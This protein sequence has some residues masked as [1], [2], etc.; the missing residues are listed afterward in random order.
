MNM[1]MNMQEMRRGDVC[2]ICLSCNSLAAL[3]LIRM[4]S[5][6]RG[7]KKWYV[8][9]DH[10]Q[11][12]MIWG[13]IS[14]VA[15]GMKFTSCQ[16]VFFPRQLGFLEFCSRNFFPQK[17]HWREKFLRRKLVH[18]RGVAKPPKSDDWATC[19]S[20][21]FLFTNSDPQHKLLSTLRRARARRIQRCLWSL[22]LN[23]WPRNSLSKSKIIT[24]W[25]DLQ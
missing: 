3:C 7:H 2:T 8:E 23:F 1:C 25:W 11:K 20:I 12:M 15:F 17:T 19:V 21:E 18:F 14:Y 13:G 4:L 22:N 5:L 24:F 6:G 16:I 9:M 10:H